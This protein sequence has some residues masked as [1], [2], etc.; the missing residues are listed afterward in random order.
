MNICVFMRLPS[1]V[2]NNNNHI[3]YVYS[4]H[5]VEHRKRN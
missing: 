4:P 2:I 5:N 3:A 1:Y